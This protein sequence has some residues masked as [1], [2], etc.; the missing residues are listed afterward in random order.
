MVEMDGVG[1]QGRRSMTERLRRRMGL[2]DLAGSRGRK[3]GDSPNS[4]DTLFTSPSV[5]YT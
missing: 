3:V 2:L 4:A 5:Y 1:S